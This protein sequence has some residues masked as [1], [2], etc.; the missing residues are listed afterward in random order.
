M[1]LH[2]NR[3]PAEDYLYPFSAIMGQE[4]MKKRLEAVYLDVEGD[5]EERTDV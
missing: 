5:I 3:T 4:E 2:N 1:E